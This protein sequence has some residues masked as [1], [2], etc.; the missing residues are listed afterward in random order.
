MPDELPLADF[1]HI[2][3]GNLAE[4]LRPLDQ[5]QVQALLDHERAHGDRLPVTQL[6]ERR[7]TDL[8]HGAEPAGSVPD[9]LPEVQDGPSGGSPASPATS[10]PPVNPPSHGVPTNPAQP[11]R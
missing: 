10:G 4:H 1:D 7:I 5:A 8:A 3:L 11:R 6:L 9:R 2:P